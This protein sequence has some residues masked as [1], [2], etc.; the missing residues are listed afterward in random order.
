M[1]RAHYIGQ[2][3]TRNKEHYYLILAFFL[4]KSGLL[5]Y[6][7]LELEMSFSG[8]EGRFMAVA[9]PNRDAVEGPS[10]IEKAEAPTAAK[11]G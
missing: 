2:R 11:T 5:P 10:T 7:F 4:L 3:A 9:V 6:H 1:L 8:A